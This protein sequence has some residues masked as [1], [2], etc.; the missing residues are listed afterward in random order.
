MPTVP[1][2]FPQFLVTFPF[3]TYFCFYYVYG[4]R[5]KDKSLQAI[6]LSG[7]VAALAFT[8]YPNLSSIMFYFLIYVHIYVI[9]SLTWLFFKLLR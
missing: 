4:S 6:G 9:G 5:R 3:L 8:M 2:G 7:L 1:P